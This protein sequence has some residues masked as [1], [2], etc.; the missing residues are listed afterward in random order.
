MPKRDRSTEKMTWR[1]M[2]LHVHTPAS[3]CYDQADATYLQILQKAEERELDIIAIT[4]HNTVA[5]IAALRARIGEL[6]LLENLKRIESN[7]RK[8]LQEYRRLGQK[9]L[10]LPGFEFTATLGFHILGIFAPE[11]STRELEHI[12]LDL[13]IPAE[14]LDAGSS[15]V[16]ATIDVLTA[17][18]VIS[19]AGGIV[20]AAHANSTH[21]VAMRGYDFG[22]QTKIAY[23]QD[24]HL[25]ALEVTDLER[26]GRRTTAAFYDGSKPEYPRR[27]FCI[28][29]SDAHR[30][31]KDPKDEHAL[32][33]GDRITEVLLPDVTFDAL[34]Q[35]FLSN[36]FTRVR[37]Y[38][39]AQSFDF[40]QA[41]QET[42]PSIVQ[43]F[44]DSLTKKGGVQSAILRDVVAMANTNGGTVFVGVGPRKKGTVHGVERPKEAAQSLLNE[45]RRTIT[46]PLEVTIDVVETRG[47]SVLRITVPKG[48]EQ[49]YALEGTKIYIRQESETNPAMRDEIVQMVQ[50]RVQLTGPSA[51]EVVAPPNGELAPPPRTGVEIVSTEERDGTTYYALKDLRNGSIIQNVTR[52]S[53]RRLWR[54]A[55]QES[56]EQPVQSDQVQWHGDIGLWKS[57]QRARRMRYDFVQRDS[58]NQ[59]HVYYGVT[60]D[61]IHGDW[62]QFIQEKA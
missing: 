19:A 8:E 23:T 29:A 60:D 27:M 10:V 36:D 3:S 31:E 55:I 17:Y 20:I 24:P 40:V 42:G 39:G 53:A 41:A 4:D 6:E 35:L 46:P 57:Y 56:E 14:K 2:D 9:L 62:R 33:V 26:S 48:E 30:V 32:G 28:Q 59:L 51:R 38:R 11:T 52:S 5:G 44:H 50:R 21:G 15:E 16:G 49:P 1:R 58:A 25:L 45:I 54:Y 47:K 34:K 43:S 22:G 7:E 13:K 12:L 18:R 37:P 61:G